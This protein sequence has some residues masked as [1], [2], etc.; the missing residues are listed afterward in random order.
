VAFCPCDAVHLWSVIR[1]CDRQR[2]DPV[3]FE[4]VVIKED[5]GPSRGLRLSA[6]AGKDAVELVDFDEVER[7]AAT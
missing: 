5:E 4:P 1:L 6:P 3:L 7:T 2:V